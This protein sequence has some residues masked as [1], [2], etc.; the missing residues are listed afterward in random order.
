MPLPFTPKSLIDALTN[1]PGGV[2]SG[3]SPLDLPPEVMAGAINTTV[4][5][6]NVTHRST[7]HKRRIIYPDDATQ[8]GVEKGR[9]QGGCYY[10]ADDQS[11]SLVALIS[12]RVF[13]FQISGD[14]LTAREITISGGVLNPTR[15]QAW[16]WQAEKW[17]IIQDGLSN[18]IFFDGT[19][20][21]AR[22]NYLAPTAFNTTTASDFVSGNGIPAIGTFGNLDFASVVGL[23]VGDIVTFATVGTFQVLTIAGATVTLL[24]LTASPV[25][26]TVAVGTAVSW[27][28]TTG[29]QLP[30]GRMGCYGMGRN[31]F[32]LVDGKQFVA[33]DIVGGASGTVANNYRDAVLYIT[34]NLFLKGGGNFTVPGSVGDITAMR[35]VAN[36]D[37]SLGQGPLQVFTHN[38]VF[39]CQAP[40]DR[41]TW[42]TV[43]NPIL[44]VSLISNGAL[45]QNS[46]VLANG[47]VIFRSIGGV[48][49]LIL[50]RREF[51]T[52][53]N[54]PISFE[55]SPMLST[56]DP[57]LLQYGSAIAFDNRLL[58]T[59]G[60]TLD[61]ETGNVYFQGL[62]PLNFDPLSG[63]RGK[64]P[65][66]WDAVVWTG[67]N[68]LQLIVGEVNR[69]ERAFAFV[70]N[71]IGDSKAIE[72]WEIK[73]SYNPNLSAAQQPLAAISDNDG[74]RD[75]PVTWQFDS[76]SLRFGIPRKD[77]QY[78]NLSNGEL[79]VS[80]LQGTVTFQTYYRADQYPCWSRW[81]S[82]QQC[83]AADS[84][85]S[86]P[87]YLP[88]EGFGAPR[89]IGCDEST[90][91]PLN[92]GYTFQVR[93]VIQ[94]HCVVI[95]EYFGADT[96]PQ[97]TFAAMQCQPICP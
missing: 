41:L 6:Q 59:V 30:P 79:Q 11:S 74:L 48:R 22:S 46:T 77:L 42:Q 31:W 35:F 61:A 32:A 34:E 93:T 65:S 23:N 47:D 14:D 13:Q 7:Y 44:Q 55:V 66:V 75:I 81:H 57:G 83:Q 85:E 38:T 2:N 71:G 9:F 68:V 1:F 95:G 91:R 67:L 73:R 60:T 94:G 26:A 37:A 62:I 69:V 36:L 53:G 58:M 84:D 86:R 20:T 24:N 56:D 88:R 17:V 28:H 3:D 27:S 54:T 64:L 89:N 82:W 25:G 10:F 51:N 76:A 96:Q 16:L 92:Q 45:G 70:L 52:W 63:L 43:T 8:T 78:L 49:S 18:P 19:T 21:A 40:V 50:A 4:R 97:P 90:D 15:P 80:D 87:G 72:I 33:G 12:G 29:T 5:G 39:S